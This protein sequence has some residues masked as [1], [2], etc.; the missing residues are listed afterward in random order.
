MQLFLFWVIIYQPP[1]IE[2]SSVTSNGTL[3][4]T[5]KPWNI[6]TGTNRDPQTRDMMGSVVS[7]V[8]APPIL[9]GA[10][11]PN[12]RNSKGANSRV[13][14]SRNTLYIKAN[15][16]SSTSRISVISMLDSE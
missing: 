3:R 5:T 15:V 9:I 14:T 2:H 4:S 12:N 6:A 7:A 11:G 8:V 13:V 1:Y 10:K 16:P